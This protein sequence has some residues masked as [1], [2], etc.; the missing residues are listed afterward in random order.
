PPRTAGGGGCLRRDRL[1]GGRQLLRAAAR[2]SRIAPHPR[3]DATDEARLDP[4][5]FMRVHRSAIVQLDRVHE[6]RGADRALLLRD[7][8]RIRVSRARWPALTAA[9]GGGRAR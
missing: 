2:R 5:R 4:N 3:D 7:G 9:L 8:T 6:L 1:G